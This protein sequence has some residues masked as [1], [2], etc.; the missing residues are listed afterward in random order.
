MSD[1]LVV[2]GG[3][4]VTVAGED[5]LVA[6]ARARV[7]A[8]E[9]QEIAR[10]LYTAAQDHELR[11]LALELDR[12]ADRLWLVS[13]LLRA[14][15]DAYS[16][17]EAG[18]ERSVETAIGHGAYWAGT[19]APVALALVPAPVV[20]G[21]AGWLALGAPG[22]APILAQHRAR[23]SDPRV[24]A[25]LRLAAGAVDDAVRGAVRLP[26]MAAVVADDRTTGL[27]GRERLARVL[28]GA[29]PGPVPAG[30]LRL[31]REGVTE[32]P[33]PG[34]LAELGARIPPPREGD[35]QLRVERFD[36]EEG[37]VYALYLGGTLEH[38]LVPREE[39]WDMASNVAAMGGAPAQ[40]QEAAVAALRASGA[41]PGDPVVL[42]G[43]SQGGLIAARLAESGEFRVAG[44]VTVGSPGGAIP[45]PEDVPVLA[46]E[47][48]EDLVPALAG[49]VAAGSRVVVTRSLYDGRPPPSERAV[50]GHELSEY[51]STLALADRSEESRVSRVRSDILGLF[52]TAGTG[53]SSAWRAERIR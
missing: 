9:L 42:V 31:R 43:Y 50:P 32:V 33:P 10:S 7:L 46:V 3:G 11:I 15:L 8:A 36:G 14:A 49:P 37:P 26:W 53:R 38:G 5:L 2:S 52:P 44:M 6:A 23:L 28:L 21:V 39:P 45:P 22:A 24:V 20:L 18:I 30:P 17:A 19:V 47:H 51:R 13:V 1:V 25:A 40:S 34:T 27:F 12:V 16:V 4:D 48:A 29:L 35:P 41:R